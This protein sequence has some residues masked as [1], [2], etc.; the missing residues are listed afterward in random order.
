MK[1]YR[2]SVVDNAARIM[3]IMQAGGTGWISYQC[4]LLNGV[5]SYK[6]KAYEEEKRVLAWIFQDDYKIIPNWLYLSKENE[7]VM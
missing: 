3:N 4:F 1:V 5:S 6:T 2:F 7:T